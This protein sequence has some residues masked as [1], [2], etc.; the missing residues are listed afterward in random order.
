M[1]HKLMDVLMLGRCSHEFSWPRRAADGHY[2]QV[3]LLCA[4]EYK[5]DWETMKRIKRLP[6]AP[7][8]TTEPQRGKD[9]KGPTWVPRARR[10]T[11]QTAVRYRPRGLGP[12]RC[13]SSRTSAI[14]R[15]HSGR[16][17]VRK[18][19][20]RSPARRTV[21]FFAR[22]ELFAGRRSANRNPSGW[23]RLFSITN[24]FGRTD[25]AGET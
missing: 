25:R 12:V 5:Y 21:Q 10:L 15:Q 8:A 1:P 24:F 14:T 3:C 7:E 13:S 18:C 6:S 20:R 2:Y 16:D 17:G 23:Q 9:V 22:A 19:R 4:A 11:L